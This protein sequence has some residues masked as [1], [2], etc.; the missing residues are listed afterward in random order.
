[1]PPNNNTEHPE[2]GFD[3]FSKPYIFGYNEDSFKVNYTIKLGDICLNF[4]KPAGGKQLGFRG[5]I[6]SGLL[7][8]WISFL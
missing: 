1:M 6:S 5:P 7:P 3:L 2:A 8:S 4:V